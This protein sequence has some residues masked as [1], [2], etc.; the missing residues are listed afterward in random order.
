MR[1]E[2][3]RV[4]QQ[5]GLRCQCLDVCRGAAPVEHAPLLGEVLAIIT[6]TDP[7]VIIGRARMQ[8]AVVSHTKH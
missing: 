3:L 5:V 2:V 7:D 4:L 8:D 1:Q 6:R